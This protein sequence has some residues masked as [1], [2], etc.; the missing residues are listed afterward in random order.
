MKRRLG[1]NSGKVH[2]N[3]TNAVCKATPKKRNKDGTSEEPLS[4]EKKC[5][6]LVVQEEIKDVPW[7]QEEDAALQN[8]VAKSGSTN[9]KYI[10]KRLNCLFK[11]KKR[12]ATECESRWKQIIPVDLPWTLHEELVLVLALFKTPG[13]LSSISSIFPEGKNVKGRVVELLT[14]VAKKAKAGQW[15]DI[16][17]SSPLRVLMLMVSLKLLL[18]GIHGS[19]QLSEVLEI[20]HQVQLEENH[21]IEL[22]VAIGK[23]IKPEAKWG[24]ESLEDYLEVATEKI[25]NSIY[26]VSPGPDGLDDVMHVRPPP[27]VPQPQS[28]AFPQDPNIQYCLVPVS[29]VGQGYYVLALC[30]VPSATP[31]QS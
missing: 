6:D 12:A 4:A 16:S 21:C 17:S 9:W 14:E 8:E 13:E 31:P 30:Y 7:T 25:Q 10:S 27:L 22:L 26:A 24:R 28:F 20:I 2:E 11:G 29:Y 1:G 5:E 23:T 15:Q 19:D 18:D 3:F